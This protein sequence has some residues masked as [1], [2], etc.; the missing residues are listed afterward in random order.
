VIKFKLDATLLLFS[1]NDLHKTYSLIVNLLHAI[2][3]ADDL[4]TVFKIAAFCSH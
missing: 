3:I 1:D 2:C 4:L